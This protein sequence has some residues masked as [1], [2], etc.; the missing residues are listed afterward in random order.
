MIK[1]IYHISDVHIRLLKRHKEYKNIFKSIYS[2]IRKNKENSLIVI[3][4]DLLHSK[5]ELSPELINV[6][7]KF[8]KTLS[9]I[10]KTIV[11][12]GNHDCNLNNPSRLDSLTPIID[13]INSKNLVL[14]KDSALYEIDNLVFSNMSV[15]GDE[16][17]YIF[18]KDIKSNKTKIALYH[19]IVIGAKLNEEFYKIVAR[20]KDKDFDGFDMVLLGDIHAPQRLQQLDPL[21]NKPEMWY[22]GSI[23]QN[24]YGEEL[25]HGYLKWDVDSRTAKFIEI[26]NDFGY[27]TI[28]VVEGEYTIPTKFSSNPRIRLQIINTQASEIQRISTD[29]RKVFNV[30][31][32]V[33]RYVEK[34]LKYSL[35]SKK[36]STIDVRDVSV[37]NKLIREFVASKNEVSNDIL[38]KICELNEENNKNLSQNENIRNIVWAPKRF[39]FSNMFSYGEDNIIDFT[40]LKGVIGLFAPNA[41]GKSSLMDA[42]MFCIFDKS[43]RAYKASSVMNNSKSSFDCKLNFEIDG[44]DFWIERKGYKTRYT[45]NVRVDVNFW[46]YGD[47]GTKIS[48]NGD[49]RDETNTNIRSYIGTYDDF[50]ATAMSFQGNDNSFI[51]KSQTDRKN[52]LAKFLDIGIFDELYDLASEKTKKI[53]TLLSEFKKQDLSGRLSTLEMD[54]DKNREL[55][56][57]FLEEKKILEESEQ[58]LNKE[59]LHNAQQKIRVNSTAI[60]VSELKSTKEKNTKKLQELYVR[61]SD[62]EKLTTQHKELAV[63]LYTRVKEMIK[64]GIEEMALK[65]NDMKRKQ[66]NLKFA[67]EKGELKIEQKMAVLKDL[68]SHEYDPNCIFCMNNVFVKKAMQTKLE[69]EEDKKI[70]LELTS[71][72]EILLKN[73][74]E[75]DGVEEKY[76]EF[77]GLKAELENEKIF[78]LRHDSELNVLRNKHSE[79]SSHNEKIDSQIDDFIKN[80]KA[81]EHNQELDF[82]ISKL[83]NE[84]ETTSSNKKI[85]E[86]KLQESMTSSEVIRAEMDKLNG[87]IQTAM[88]MESEFEA[89]QLYAQAISRDGVPYEL[90][91]NTIPLLHTEVNDILSQ[92]VDFNIVFNLD[93]KNVNAFIAYDEDKFWP[94]ELVSGMEKFI[95]SLA[96]RCAL[97]NISNLSRPIFLAVDEGFGVLDADNISSLGYLFDYLKQKFDFVL[98]VSHIDTMK[99]MVDFALDISKDGEFSKIVHS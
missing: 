24:N 46:S 20:I 43:S 47:D 76:K 16:S 49:N 53:N 8:L 4:G 17:K 11:V 96:I 3:T 66:S 45:H 6:T 28:D 37:Q 79:V 5:T 52:F 98:I 30:Q 32:I 81:I 74:E 29:L 84:L 55:C 35:S 44:V 40:K 27:H 14:W 88:E 58:E 26:Q 50:V 9:T 7:S 38:D 89:S 64:S 56:L 91:A 54:Y 68:E 80:K 67:V 60:D 93:G 48:L 90:I 12:L 31:E 34:D 39:E 85:I 1:T 72:Y 57:N 59:L 99:D 10:T 73:I 15:L 13:T 2:E 92:I 86:K 95:S 65:L 36:N 61:L 62:S 75:L 42:L 87:L 25:E 21:L 71:E 63:A 22:A 33:H 77:N 97:L 41:T 78:A 23:V 82:V 19:G 83:S 18:A 69:L 70:Q 94:I 51:D